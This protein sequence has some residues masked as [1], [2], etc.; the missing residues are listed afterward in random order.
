MLPKK[1]LSR[2]GQI[3]RSFI[4]NGPGLHRGRAKVACT[5]LTCPQEEGGVGIKVLEEW[6][7]A[8][9]AK[10]LWQLSH[11]NPTSSWALWARANL[12]QGQSFWDIN[13]P[14]NCSWGW[15]N[16]LQM[17]TIYRPYIQHTIGDGASV[18]LWF[19]TGSPLVLFNSPLAFDSFMTPD[20][21]G[22]LEWRQ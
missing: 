17:H 7:R 19:D 21:P 8:S 12:L 5:D 2:I 16:I 11:P 6:N 13:V 20:F 4:W 14:Q 10:Y 9:M 22:M 1:T 18:S 3:M 15:R